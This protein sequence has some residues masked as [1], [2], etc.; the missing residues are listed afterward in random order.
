MAKF[1]VLVSASSSSE[2]GNMPSL[3]E[4][5]EMGA[6][7]DQL[8]QAGVLLDADGFLASSKGARINFNTEGPSKP[9]YGPFELDNL[10]AGYWFWQLETLEQAIEW[11]GKIPFKNGRVEIR[12]IACEED[13]GAEVRDFLKK[14]R[15]DLAK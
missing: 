15:D 7:N 13:F 2:A 12:H 5:N 10:V 4:M 14:K 9:E 6:F 3:D 8:R 11:A 1:A